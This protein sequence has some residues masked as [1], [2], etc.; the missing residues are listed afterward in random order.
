MQRHSTDHLKAMIIIAWFLLIFP[1][2]GA[3]AQINLTEAEKVFIKEHPMVRV[4]NE[5]D[6][7]P[8]DYAEDGK[9]KGYSIDLLNII[10]EKTGLKLEYINGFRWDELLNMGIQRRIDVFPAIWKTEERKKH[11]LFTTSYIDT[12]YI[13]VIHQDRQDISSI[14]TLKGRILTGIK[15]FASTEQVKAHYPGIEVLEVESA[16]EGLRQVSY[17]RADAYLGS[18]AETNFVINRHL[19]PNLKIAGE[20]DLGG[21]V[22]SP[23]LYIG[24]RKDWPMLLQIIQRGMDAITQGEKQAL[25]L[26]WL[27][28]N[29]QPGTLVLNE[30]ERSFLASHPVLRMGFDP[31]WPPVTYLNRNNKMSG[32]AE[33]YLEIVGQKLGVKVEPVASENWS[34]VPRAVQA[35]QID[36]LTGIFPAG[37][38]R[39]GLIFTDPYL[40][41]PIVIVTREDVPYVSSP[42]F[43]ENKTVAVVTGRPFHGQLSSAHP[44]IRIL[45]VNRVKDGLLAVAG[46]EAFAFV[47][48][49]AAAGHVIGREGFTT[50]KVS[51]GTPY[52]LEVA[53]G[54]SK[55]NPVLRDLLQKAMAGISTEEQNNIYSKW[56][57]V[58]FEYQ[59]DYSMMWKLGSGGLVFLLLVLYWNRRLRRMANDLE[60]AR[61]QAEAANRSKSIFLANMSHEL[62]TPLNAILGFSQIMADD[63]GLDPTQKEN[64][65]IINSSGEHLLSLISDILDMSK[66]EAGRIVLKASVFSLTDFMAHIDDMLRAMADEKGLYLKFRLAPGL[67]GVIRADK[68]RLRQVL[69]NLIVNGIKNTE[70]G[71]VTV[72][73]ASG[74]PFAPPDRSSLC[75]AVRD[76][77]KGIAPEY[78][79]K[80]FKPFMQAGHDSQAPGGTGLGLSIC[81]TL[82]E[83]M[84]GTI[85]LDSE[86]GEG[87]GF[88]FTIEIQKEDRAGR[89]DGPGT[90]RAGRY[91]HRVLA[92]DQP[93]Y[94]ILVVDDSDNNRMLLTSILDKA[95]FLVKGAP[96][97]ETAFEIIHDWRPHLVWMDI[98][99][100]GMDGLAATRRI[101]Q[102]QDPGLKIIGISASAFEEDRIAC[103][104]AGCD[105]FVAKPADRQ[106]VL[107]KMTRHLGAAFV[108]PEETDPEPPT[109]GRERGKEEPWGPVLLDRIPGDI[110]TRLEQAVFSF[111]YEMT[112]SA[113]EK[114]HTADPE[115]GNRLSACAKVYQFETLQALFEKRSIRNEQP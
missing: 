46:K 34:D 98:Q 47:G 2:S 57:S 109:K 61:D 11:F 108:S 37:Q 65:R 22:E 67:P 13:L 5:M 3:A 10:A 56:A 48:S 18:M 88:S 85:V 55:E 17:G 21:R 63:K 83:M 52:H 26:K 4:A 113:I 110:T 72:S 14:E 94:R 42:A 97:A 73:V 84:G 45:K 104:E 82:V 32:M 9:A 111:D 29:K 103:M 19:V 96:C 74:S 31:D 115:L 58:T 54:C 33:D 101:R 105:D 44:G 81:Q 41:F 70:K 99:M 51:G 112:L 62:R 78:R 1:F 93:R 79:D 30:S 24:I 28:F 7:T 106:E 27:E 20:T 6:W 59:P 38:D 89:F 60:A 69:V 92:P 86:T 39:K 95:G 66:I 77:G 8:F 91:H 15:G 80:I 75:F 35:G 43:L 68:A 71:G 100:E 102:K 114:I 12:P 40:S 23:L 87:S 53:L 64:L 50:L 36:F 76:T 49:L 25:H 90:D 107:K 16:A